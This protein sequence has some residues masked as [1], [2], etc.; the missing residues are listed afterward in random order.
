M[1]FAG[2]DGALSTYLPSTGSG[3]AVPA[4]A[5]DLLVAVG[6]AAEPEVRLSTEGYLAERGFRRA[7]H[8]C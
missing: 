1:H 3:H 8:A 7:H 5:A 4:R 2:R 6:A